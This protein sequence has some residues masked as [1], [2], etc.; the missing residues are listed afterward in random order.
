MTEVNKVAA[1]VMTGLGNGSGIDIFQ[2]ATDL[3]NVERLPKQRAIES[4]QAKTEAAISAYSVLAFQVNQL[5]TAFSAL[6]DASELTTATGNSSKSAQIAITSTT[7]NAFSGTR[8][9]SAMYQIATA[10]LSCH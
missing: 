5:K 4:A 7:G 9:R 1:Q 6:N 2:L 10:M 8:C 3:T